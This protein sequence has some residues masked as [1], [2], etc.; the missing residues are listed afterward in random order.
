[1]I[2]LFGQILWCKIYKFLAL[3]KTKL[4]KN[5]IQKYNFIRKGYWFLLWFHGTYFVKCHQHC[6]FAWCLRTS[7]FQFFEYFG[8]KLQGK[9]GCRSQSRELNGNYS[10][11]FPYAVNIAMC[12]VCIQ[13]HWRVSLSYMMEQHMGLLHP[14]VII[15]KLKMKNKLGETLQPQLQNLGMHPCLKVCLKLSALL[16]VT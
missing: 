7:I 11:Q 3:R 14:N 5:I 1:M 12:P 15:T 16:S 6:S 9:V 10:R 13:R 4:L 2:C 8:F